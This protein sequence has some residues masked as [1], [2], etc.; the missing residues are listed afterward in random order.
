MKTIAVKLNAA[1]QKL[2]P[3]RNIRVNNDVAK[4]IEHDNL[5]LASTLS[6]GLFIMKK[7]GRHAVSGDRSIAKIITGIPR[8][9]RLKDADPNNYC[10]SSFNQPKNQSVTK[11]TRKTKVRQ[12]RSVKM[13]L[14]NG[15]V[16]EGPVNELKKLL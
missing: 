10:R 4:I 1:G 16:F 7:N 14:P 9:R 3:T 8:T 5:E 2:S 11:K 12:T 13:T 15:T 6:G